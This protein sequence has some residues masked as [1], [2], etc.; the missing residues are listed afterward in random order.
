MDFGL[1]REHLPVMAGGPFSSATWN[2]LG[3]LEYYLSAKIF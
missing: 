3:W 2:G 1:D